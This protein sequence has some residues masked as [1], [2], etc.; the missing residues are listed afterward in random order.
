MAL[1]AKK[2]AEHP[3]GWHS[4][5][6]NLRSLY[7]G[8]LSANPA[9]E[10]DVLEALFE[11]T[12]Y[13]DARSVPDFATQWAELNRIELRLVRTIEDVQLIEET[14][15]KLSEARALGVP[16]VKAFVDRFRELEA[17]GTAE[18]RR[19]FAVT[20][21]SEVYGVQSQQFVEREKRRSVA[22]RLIYIGMLIVGIPF[23]VLLAGSLAAPFF[24]FFNAFAPSRW[25]NS[26]L[27]AFFLVLYFGIV[28]AY[29]SRLSRF[30]NRM[31]SLSWNEMDL[32]YSAGAIN[33]RLL[34]GAIA[35]LILFFLMMGDILSG[36]VFLDGEFVLWWV[37]AAGNQVVPL[38]PSENFAR[39]IVWCI[40]A[41][42][43]ERFVPDRINEVSRSAEGSGT[44]SA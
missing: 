10:D 30:A 7:E 21:I 41:G 16:D 34:V 35:A 12:N 37:D 9:G 8:H 3:A 2:K 14:R 22:R 31:G 6:Q 29:F 28:G 15:H 25:A 11:A 23:T 42:F 39:L 17:K 44:Q 18:E 13:K 36:P 5:R 24:E 27:T 38:R 19:A 43:S 20:L 32:G 26:E 33:V 40:V 1:F 4:Y